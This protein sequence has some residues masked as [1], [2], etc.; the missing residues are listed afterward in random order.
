[1]TQ[2]YAPEYLD[3]R[4]DKRDDRGRYQGDR[5]DRPRCV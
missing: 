5:D 3:E 2:D 4:Y 1:M